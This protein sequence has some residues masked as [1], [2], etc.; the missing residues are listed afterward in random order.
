[1]HAMHVAA[2]ARHVHLKQSCT[3][4]LASRYLHSRESERS[5]HQHSHRAHEQ[6]AVRLLAE[7]FKRQKSGHVQHPQDETDK[8]RQEQL[9]VHQ[10]L[11]NVR[12]WLPVR[13]QPLLH[14]E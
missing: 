14:T 3:K 7:R 9:R 4:L 13:L 8:E 12:L 10:R 11:E 1:M 6:Q 2:D 5:T